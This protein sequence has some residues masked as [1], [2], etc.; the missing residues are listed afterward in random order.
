MQNCYYGRK[1]DWEIACEYFEHFLDER[2]QVEFATNE[3]NTFEANDQ[4]PGIFLAV[5]GL[6]EAVDKVRLISLGLEM[7]QQFIRLES[8]VAHIEDDASI[9]LSQRLDVNVFEDRLD[10]FERLLH[11]NKIACCCI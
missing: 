4:V 11:R 9:R 5:H 3:W 8:K 6:N 1:I 7:S 10:Y 2:A